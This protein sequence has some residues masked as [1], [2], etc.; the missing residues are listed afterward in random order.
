MSTVGSASPVRTVLVIDDDSGIREIVTA[1]LEMVAG[2]TVFSAES[3]PVGIE[4]A[5]E[6]RPDV[7]LV[8]VMMPDMD[9][10]ATVNGL[11]ARADT[12]DIPVIMLTAK[13]RFTVGNV[14]QKPFDPLDL[15]SQ[16]E[17]FMPSKP[18]PVAPVSS[19]RAAQLQQR[20]SDLWERFRPR[21]L[22]LLDRL[23]EAVATLSRGELDDAARERARGDA[24]DLKGVA[25][26]YGF[27]R[28]S[29]AARTLMEMFDDGASGPG[30]AG[31]MLR[32]VRLVRDE[33]TAR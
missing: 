32:L 12:R 33:F 3:G 14:I 31:E 9:G 1:T 6:H 19:D 27:T 8:D 16:I 7:I 20:M 11:R 10:P 18:P 13:A 25:G 4:M 15:P 26:T 29:D 2:W 30:P 22:E 5:A 17:S 21:M 23:D 24:H 28:S